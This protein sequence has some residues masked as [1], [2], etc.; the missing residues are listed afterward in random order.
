MI[1]QDLVQLD[2][3]RASD[4]VAELR[5]RLPGYLTESFSADEGAGSALAWIHARYVES[6]LDRL[7]QV[8]EKTKLVFLDQL[9]IEPTMARAARAPMV[10]QLSEKAAAISLPAGSRIAA[11]PPPGAAEQIVFETEYN[12]GL[13]PAR[14][15]EV[16]SLWPGRDEYIDHSEQFLSGASIRPFDRRDLKA[17]PHELYIAHDTLLNLAGKV[18]L[19]VEF[20]LSQASSEMLEMLWEYWDGKVWRGF[21]AQ[22]PAC[23]N[24][25]D[26]K[27]DGTNGLTHSGTIRLETDSGESGT[28]DVHGIEAYWIRAR[29]G[30][31]LPIDPQQILPEVA[32]LSLSTVV[33]RSLTVVLASRSQ[34]FI[35]G[36]AIILVELK[37]TN[38]VPIVGAVLELRELVGETKVPEL[39]GETSTTDAKGQHEFKLTDDQPRSFELIVS[40]FDSRH[41]LTLDYYWSNPDE[42]RLNFKLVFQLGGLQPDVAI[43]DNGPIDLN[44]PFAPL[45]DYPQP[46]STFYFSSAEAFGKP[47]AQLTI[48]LTCVKT[49]QDSFD[50]T[51]SPVR[52]GPSTNKIPLEHR[53]NWEYWDGRAWMLLEY[54][55][56]KRPDSDGAEKPDISGRASDF[57]ESMKFDLIVP[58]DMAPVNVKD[59]EALWMRARLVTGGYGFL[60]QVTFD[61]NTFRSVITQ[62]PAIADFR[63]SYKWT[64]GPFPAEH[65]LAFNDFTYADCTDAARW[66]GISFKPFTQIGDLLPALYIGHN[67]PL[68]ADRVNVFFDVAESKETSVGAVLV[69][70]YWNGFRWRELS[71][72]DETHHL[73]NS[74]MVGLIGPNDA[75]CRPRFGNDLYWLRA[76]LKEDGPPP[77]AAVLGIYANAVWASQQQTVVNEEIGVSKGLPN[78][79]FVVRRVPI[80]EGERIE[81][82][83]RTGERANVEWRILALS[84]FDGDRQVLQELEQQLGSETLETEFV[85][86][87]LRLRRDRHKR[88][89][90]VWIRWEGRRN[91]LD[92]GPEDRHYVLDRQR[93]AFRLGNGR[94]GMTSPTGAQVVARSYRYGGGAAA[95]VAARAISQLLAGVAGIDAVFNPKPAEGGADAET[96]V[97][98][99]DRGPRTIRHRG[100][101]VT[102]ADYEVMAVEASPV[103]AV[104]QALAGRDLQGRRRA[105]WVTLV[106]IPRSDEPRPW[107]SPGLREQ[108]RRY[109]E[110]RCP[111]AVANAQQV[112]VTGPDYL[113]IDVEATIAPLVAPLAGVAET[114]ARFAIE[115]FLHPLTGG[116]LQNG[117]PAGRDVYLSDL[118]GVLERVPEIDYVREL[119]LLLDGVPRGEAVVVPAGKVV[120]A[121]QIRIKVVIEYQD[122]K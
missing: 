32:Q 74:G 80:L 67:L 72:S 35:K 84:L 57:T 56:V 2:P 4:V 36:G 17:T 108:I 18:K 111:A 61:R 64:F 50:V 75:Q 105:G 95:N 122:Q 59:K 87:D 62:P 1:S 107:P 53:I 71:A 88:V 77:Q 110:A 114:K 109:I 13:T 30:E 31:R 12:V 21:K 83:E 104:A 28:V 43:N 68:P 65:V 19:D 9:G 24:G 73:A 5:A 112:F 106:V 33:E 60:Q 7:N 37:D 23:S 55:S 99:S 20:D 89:S 86:G 45:G 40:I 90:E 78:E 94:Q 34:P 58:G 92:S 15:A 121:G 117:W 48:H 103:V 70:E 42:R 44:A 10:F 14:I 66:P 85:R 25:V 49:P 91:F 96:L 38:D 29:L 54:C 63:I 118:S 113:P 101:A 98:F 8:P 46:R 102:G 51:I 120:V 81:I 6:L 16:V 119:T 93:G 115:K 27:L 26:E 3:R 52:G 116:P 39:E 11:S 79:T 47:G 97:A 41:V 22:R 82:R 76:R 69:W 100:R